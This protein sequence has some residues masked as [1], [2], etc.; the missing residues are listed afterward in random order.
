MVKWE[1]LPHLFPI[2][3]IPICTTWFT[4]TLGLFDEKLISHMLT[5][6][7]FEQQKELKQTKLIK[8]LQNVYKF[9][10]YTK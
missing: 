3:V 6:Y 4:Y 8:E 9:I 1:I 2:T 5:M 10:I 7:L